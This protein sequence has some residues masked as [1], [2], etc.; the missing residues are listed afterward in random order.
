MQADSVQRWMHASILNSQS[1]SCSQ[2]PCSR[3]LLYLNHV[4][5]CRFPLQAPPP[6][7]AGRPA[8]RRPAARRAGRGLSM[9]DY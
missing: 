8:P 7:A 9:K 4:Y 3:Y 5:N 1:R 6:R 2:L